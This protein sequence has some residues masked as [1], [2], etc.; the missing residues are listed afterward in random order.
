MALGW[1]VEQKALMEWHMK[2]VS[3]YPIYPFYHGQNHR[4]TM[5][6]K[7]QI[8]GTVVMAGLTN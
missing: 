3:A 2:Y 7:S 1:A 8:Q 5:G 6:L 4:F